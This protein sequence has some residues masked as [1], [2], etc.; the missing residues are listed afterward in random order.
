MY[1][2]GLRELAQ[3]TEQEHMRESLRR[4]AIRDARRQA[5]VTWLQMVRARLS[6]KHTA[7]SAAGAAR[8]VTPKQV[9][10]PAPVRSAP[11]L[12]VMPAAEID[13]PAGADC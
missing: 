2:M 4:A 13:C 6:P 3:I 10:A 7:P 9:V 12:R 11:R 5:G 8:Q 1:H